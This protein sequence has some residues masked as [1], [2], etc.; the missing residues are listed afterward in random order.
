MD[1]LESNLKLSITS[2]TRKPF[3]VL[4]TNPDKLNIK[5]KALISGFGTVYRQTVYRQPVYRQPVYRQPVYRQ[6]VLSTACFSTASLSTASLS[7][8]P[9]YRDDV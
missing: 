8:R 5:L 9:F 4:H 2:L 7:T 3:Q 1:M 6:T